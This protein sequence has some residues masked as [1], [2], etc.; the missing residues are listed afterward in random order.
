VDP[1]SCVIKKANLKPH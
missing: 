1:L